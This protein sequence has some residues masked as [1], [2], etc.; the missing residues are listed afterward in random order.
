MSYSWDRPLLRMTLVV[1][2]GCGVARPV[3]A[4]T[5]ELVFDPAAVA[6]LVESTARLLQLVGLNTQDL[7]AL[8]NLGPIL[9]LA[10][11]ITALLPEIQSITATFDARTQG[12]QSLMATVPCTASAQL[13]WLTQAS[14]WGRHG[15]SEALVAMRLVGRT[16]GF[17]QN[18]LSLV[19]TISSLFGTTSG[20]Q[21][22]AALTS[23][24]V[25]ELQKLQ[26]VLMPAQQ[27]LM[28][29]Q[30]ITQMTQLSNSCLSAQRFGGWGTFTTY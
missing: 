19:S 11:Q 13:A 26:V 23:V 10:S 12:W 2:M 1:L 16:V 15:S 20:L 5:P 14:E 29:G 18:L 24:T 21:L 7:A 30:M 27:V 4:Q 25:V 3:S 28:G 8:T 22:N 6:Q 17:L 9:E